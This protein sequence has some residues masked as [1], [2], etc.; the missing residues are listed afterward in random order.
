[1]VTVN[2]RSKEAKSS[3][4]RQAETLIPDIGKKTQ[5]FR[6]KD[7]VHYFAQFSN[8]AYTAKPKCRTKNRLDNNTCENNLTEQRNLQPFCRNSFY[9]LR[10]SK[11]IY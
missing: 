2:L 6:R 9:F 11:V 7:K 3:G 4:N 10:N 1:M 5:C 8:V